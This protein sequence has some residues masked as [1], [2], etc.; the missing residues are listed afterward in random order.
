MIASLRGRIIY[1]TPL[2]LIL[3]VNGIGYKVFTS[4]TT[5]EKLKENEEIFLY[6]YLVVK[7]D[8]LD[9]YGFENIDERN[10]FELL[11]K[12]NGVGPRLAI[13][14]LSRIS[15]IELIK[16][17]QNKNTSIIK[18]IHGVGAKT[19]DKIIIELYDKIKQ[20]DIVGPSQSLNTFTHK[21]DAIQALVV[22]GYSEKN[23]EKVVD[24]IISQ[25]PDATTEEIL[26]AS[27]KILTKR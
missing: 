6:T 5:S 22:L 2:Y 11:L 12:V 19:A 23:V 10:I 15:T 24:E 18:S 3:D 8:A 25:N 7:E 14:I 26:K 9:L 1:K 4:I 16:A 21:T 13:N 20:I 17:I 27:L